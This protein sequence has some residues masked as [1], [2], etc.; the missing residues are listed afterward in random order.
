MS[1]ESLGYLGCFV[2]L[3]AA[4]MTDIRTMKIPNVITLSGL[5]A[6]LVWNLL[7]GGWM[8]GLFALKGI[9]AGFGVMLLLYF[10]GAVG[11]GDVKLFA[12]IGAWT[13]AVM[14]LYIMMY[15]I[16]A[17][18]LIGILVLIL[19]REI[20]SRLRGALRN[21]L[22]SYILKSWSP[23]RVGAKKQLQIPFML[24]VLPGAI[25]AVYYLS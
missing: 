3:A 2:M 11:G 12:A 19:R 23:I 14:T 10:L 4:F 8:G 6:G 15:S 5:V 16:F 1:W 21:V 22:G 17:A 13:G 18:G 7:Y 9:A 24:A 20:F 25:L